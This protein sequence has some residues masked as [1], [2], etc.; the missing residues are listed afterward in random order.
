MRAA[1]A[2]SSWTSQTVMPLQLHFPGVHAKRLCRTLDALLALVV[3]IA[4]S[5]SYWQYWLGC[6]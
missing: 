2:S 4:R 5:L 3:E 6:L 1:S